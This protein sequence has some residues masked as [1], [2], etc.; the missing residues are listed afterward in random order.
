[1]NIKN[2]DVVEAKIWRPRPQ[3][4]GQCWTFEAKAI[5]PEAKVFEHTVIAESKI[6]STSNSLTEFRLLF[7]KIFF[8]LL[9][10]VG[11]LPGFVTGIRKDSVHRWN[12][13]LVY[14]LRYFQGG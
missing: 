10:C 11:V 5:G 13:W 12:L 7:A 9:V 1:M 3:G 4:Q 6:D 2:S 8:L 14:S